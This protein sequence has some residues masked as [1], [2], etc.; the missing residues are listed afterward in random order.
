MNLKDPG[1][2]K[3]TRT[4]WLAYLALA[5]IVVGFV[6]F[7]LFFAESLILGGDALN[8]F[9]RDG[10][11]YLA[12][13]GS[14]TEVDQAT[15]ELSRFHATSVFVTHPLALAGMAYLLFRYAFPSLMGLRGD[16]A[17][18][19]RIQMVMGSGP[20][21][22]SGGMSGQVGQVAFRGV[23]FDVMVYPGGLL[24]KPALI[25]MFAILASEITAVRSRRRLLT[26]A[27][28]IEHTGEGSRSPLILRIDADSPV[29][30]AIGAIV[31]SPISTPA[32]APRLDRRGRAR[33]I[34]D[35]I[36]SFGYL[37]SD[38]APRGVVPVL[39]VLGFAVAIVLITT[40]ITWAIP[41]L[42]AFGVVWT[43]GVIAILVVNLARLYRGSR[44]G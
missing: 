5:A 20:M 30:T 40:G 44:G 24:V 35:S 7:F 28:D 21:I 22:T 26:T 43:L 38:A 32:Q 10:H 4:D 42:G 11:Y 36:L 12:N 33:R 39:N 16:A 41:K 8:G 29:A 23:P 3:N 17:D 9:V 34:G 19:A 37:P 31:P 18:P 2:P 15:W 13:H 6:N 27:I 25:P 1:V 14:L